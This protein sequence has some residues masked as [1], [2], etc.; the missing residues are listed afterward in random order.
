MKSL[1]G[2]SEDD[3]RIGDM[4]H[5]WQ[6]ALEEQRTDDYYAAKRAESEFRIEGMYREV[7]LFA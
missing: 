3:S 7:D 2:P 5:R 4:K 6:G 1:T